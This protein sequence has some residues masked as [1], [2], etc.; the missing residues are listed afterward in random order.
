MK[1][2]IETLGCPKNVADSESAAGILERAGHVIVKD[3]NEAD[4]LLAV[5]YPHLDVYK[6]QIVGVLGYE[7]GNGGD[8]AAASHGEQGD[9]HVVIAR[10]KMEVRGDIGGHIHHLRDVAAGFFDPHDSGVAA[11]LAHGFWGDVYAGAPW[12]LSLIHI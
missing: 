3:P 4:V 1:C 8:D 2:F 12:N 9:H 7:V 10:V 11:E 5:S 6:S